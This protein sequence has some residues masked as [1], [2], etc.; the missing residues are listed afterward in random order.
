MD[1]EKSKYTASKVWGGPHRCAD[2]AEAGGVDSAP[3]GWLYRPQE[4]TGTTVKFGVAAQKAVDE[5]IE[6]ER[7]RRR[8]R[9]EGPRKLDQK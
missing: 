6:L 5:T 8:I 3:F 9:V 2:V 7:E 1:E 4:P